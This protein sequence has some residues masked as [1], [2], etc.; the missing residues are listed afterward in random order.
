MPAIHSVDQDIPSSRGSAGKASG[1]LRPEDPGY[2][3]A[4][5]SFNLAARIHPRVAI[6]ATSAREVIAAVDHAR[7]R[8]LPIRVISTG[9]GATAKPSV[10][11][12]LLIRTRVAGPVQVDPQSRTARVPAGAT[13]SEVAAATSPYG[14]VA[15]HGSSGSVGAVGYLLRGGISF[16]GRRFGLAVNSL[17]SIT[18]VLADGAQ[19]TV[20]A[21]HDPELFWALR[22]GGGGFGVV[23]EV[24][25]ALRPMAAIFAGATIWDA[26][27][28]API[29]SRWAAWTTD[30]P[31][32][33]STSLRLMNLPPSPGV[34][35]ILT[36]GQ[37]LVIDGA[38]TAE[39][40]RDLD[41]TARIATDLLA[42]LR[43][44]AAPLLDTWHP[45]A[46][47]E[48]LDV[49]MDPPAPLP[50][51]GDH[52]LLSDP[53]EEGLAR[54]LAAAG[55]DAGHRLTIAELRQLGGAFAQ[56]TVAGGA[57]DRVPAPLAYLAI[58]VTPNPGEADRVRNTLSRVAGAV[59]PWSTGFTV[60]SVVED[61]DAVQRTFDDHTAAAVRSVRTRVDPSGMFA[62]DVDPIRD[63]VDPFS[64]AMEAQVSRRVVGKT[65]HGW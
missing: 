41:V 53:G 9:H 4:T 49:H 5:E 46:P 54:F 24:E 30:A 38:V 35:D 17:R 26:H 8:A 1:Y 12:V 33:M 15:L 20:S 23:T 55:P 51:A 6:V 34:P 19:V 56:P 45:T 14:L 10:A 37:I 36:A 47:A 16:Y 13:W 27:H 62:Q 61:H 2:R 52:M 25:V 59:R 18:I 64:A 60:P 50:Y 22:G 11:D 63:A 28:A 29:L 3:A 40:D 39:Q 31:Q 43:E 44:A 32:E 57:L 65:V 58:G 21:D 7:R 42:P 48:L